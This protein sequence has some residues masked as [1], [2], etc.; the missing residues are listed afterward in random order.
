MKHFIVEIIYKVP[1][2]EFGDAVAAHRTY[3][4]KGYELGMI[5]FSGPQVPRL[6]GILVARAENAQQLVD[7]F[8]KDPYKIRGLADFRFIQ[9]DPVRYQPCLS[10]WFDDDDSSA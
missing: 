2:E 4:S 9:F 8:E 10:E 7:F 1:F 3:L 5:L 6:G